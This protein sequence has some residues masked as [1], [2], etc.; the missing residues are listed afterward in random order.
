MVQIDVTIGELINLKQSGSMN[1]EKYI[2]S[3]KLFKEEKIIEYMIKFVE[4]LP[5]EEEQEEDNLD[6]D[7]EEDAIIEDMKED[8]SKSG[9]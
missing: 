4:Q 1:I 8:G 6:D 9:F 7:E 5:I 2:N 3:L